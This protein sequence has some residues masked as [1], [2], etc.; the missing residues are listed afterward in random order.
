VYT[1]F[2]WGNS[3]VR[4]HLGDPGID[5]KI[6]LRWI[7]RKWDVWVW[8]GP[9]SEKS[10]RLLSPAIGTLSTLSRSSLF[11]SV[12]DSSKQCG[13]PGARGTQ[14]IACTVAILLCNLR[15]TSKNS[16]RRKLSLQGEILSSV[17]LL[18]TADLAA[19]SLPHV[20]N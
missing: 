19:L 17:Q 10:Q 8:T 11:S 4:D 5:G 3:R 12:Q 6:I 16:K 13:L 9:I 7:F 2:W 20:A 15:A 18:G 14:S 1:G